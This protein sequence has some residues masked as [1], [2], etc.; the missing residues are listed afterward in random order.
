MKKDIFIG[1][2]WPYANY[3]LHI[4]HLAA[5]LP[6]DVIARYY[7]GK[8]DNVIYVSGTDTHGTPITERAKKEGKTPKEIAE[9]YHAKDVN[10]FNNYNFTYDL[11]T[12]TMTEEHTNMVKDYYMD[13]VR[14]G[15]IYEKEELQD[16]CDHCDKYL[17]DREIVGKCPHCGGEATGDQCEECLATLNSNEVLD[18]HCKTCNS[19]TVL[20]E[21]KHL[22]FK[23]S[24]FSDK[25]AE[26]IKNNSALW[27]NNAVGETQKFVDMG[28]Q[29]RCTTRQLDWGIDVP[30]DGY[31]DKK[32]YVWIE[33]VMGYLTA[34]KQVADSRGIDFEKFLS[35]NNE[36]LESYYIHGK[37]NI[38][39]HTVI[40]PA[41]LEGLGHNYQLPKHIVSSNYVNLNDQKISKSKGNMITA[42]ELAESYDID[43]IRYYLIA[44]GPEQKDI[45]FSTS[46]LEQAHNKF[47][48]GVLGNFVNRNLSFVNKKFDGIIAEGRIDPD[49]KELTEKEYKLIGALI[50]KGELKSAINSVIEYIS[51]GN[52][53]YDGKQPWILVKED[54]DKF[55][56]V[57]Y[58]CAYMIANISNL[59]N[60]FMPNTSA[61]I[62]DMLN[63]PEFKWEPEEISGNYKI[64]NTDLLF[65]RIEEKKNN[66]NVEKTAKKSR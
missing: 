58:T 13:L 62:K 32:I 12:S 20:K 4:G 15:Y 60:P 35:K 46:D 2:A 59:I 56:D 57:S 48:V 18:K 1:G 24:A 50:E 37:D 8:G 40:Y 63:L 17:S 49:I 52:K 3:Q 45:S 42:D 43:T 27:R 33:A 54:L 9:F 28:L 44:N 41:L 10:T 31:E 14:N 34:G 26:L 30:V 29:D 66:L 47:L 7:R 25:I 39:F 65:T 22:Y 6:G 51:Y 53:Y 16:F 23:L 38:P 61:K 11:Y 19:P 5:L 64:Q 21:N 55:N 36:N